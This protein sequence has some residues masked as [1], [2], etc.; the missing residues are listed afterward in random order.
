MISYYLCCLYILPNVNVFFINVKCILTNFLKIMYFEQYEPWC[1]SFLWVNFCPGCFFPN[2]VHLNSLCGLLFWLWLL[3][4]GPTIPLLLF[5]FSF[6]V[7]SWIHQALPLFSF[8]TSL[9]IQISRNWCLMFCFS[10]C[11]F[12]SNWETREW[13]RW[14]SDATFIN[15]E[16]FGEC[17]PKAVVSE[18]GRITWSLVVLNNHRNPSSGTSRVGQSRMCVLSW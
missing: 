14:R 13:G 1:A 2:P 6:C 16:G 7:F 3:M 8:I 5:V 17:D 18:L 11:V 10:P 15:N 12:W 4:C 9:K